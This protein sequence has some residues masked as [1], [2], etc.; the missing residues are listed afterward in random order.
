MHT[1]TYAHGLVCDRPADA[2]PPGICRSLFGELDS[3]EQL[4][5]HFSKLRDGSGN[6][7]MPALPALGPGLDAAVLEVLEACLRLDPA[8]RPTARELLDMEFF[9]KQY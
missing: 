1:Y 3:P 9:G 4:Y 6:T 5:Q 7:S 2:C 8:A